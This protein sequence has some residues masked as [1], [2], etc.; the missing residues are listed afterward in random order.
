MGRIINF[1]RFAIRPEEEFIREELEFQQLMPINSEAFDILACVDELMFATS[2]MISIKLHINHVSTGRYLT[3]LASVGMLERYFFKYEERQDRSNYVV[4]SI[5]YVGMK[6]LAGKGYKHINGVAVVNN[7]IADMPYMIKHILASNNTLIHIFGSRKYEKYSNKSIM[8]FG[9][10]K[11]INVKAYGLV[12]QQDECVL[13]EP[14]RRGSDS[15]AMLIDRIEKF[16]AIFKTPNSLDVDHAEMIIVAEDSLHMQELMEIVNDLVEK[17][18][19]DNIIVR[20]A[21]DNRINFQN[22]IV[23]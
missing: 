9:K 22:E 3:S 7:I 19:I 18:N 17:D 2:D 8:N 1:T 11:L 10:G 6:M 20:Y 4:Y 14:V 23:C 12:K 21:F 16:S 5:T 15:I 13:I